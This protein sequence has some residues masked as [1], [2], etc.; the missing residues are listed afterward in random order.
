M[1][2]KSLFLWALRNDWNIIAFCCCRLDKYAFSPFLYSSPSCVS[3]TWS[4]LSSK[5]KQKK[6]AILN[7]KRFLL[8]FF[9]CLWQ[10]RL[11]FSWL[12][13]LFWSRQIRHYLYHN[14]NVTSDEG[15]TESTPSTAELKTQRSSSERWWTPIPPNCDAL[16]VVRDG[17]NP[18]Y[19]QKSAS[20][21]G[22]LRWKLLLND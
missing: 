17:I 22:F 12:T 3:S 5:T 21:L 9:F 11:T 6:K 19:F 15:E 20:S 1:P 7:Y 4:L 16:V 10:N 2:G 13:L 18:E 8:F 14:G